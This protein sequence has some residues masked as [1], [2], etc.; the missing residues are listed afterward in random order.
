MGGRVVVDISVGGMWTVV[1]AVDERWRFGRTAGSFWLG[2][3]ITKSTGG[4][5]IRILDLG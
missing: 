2:E 5:F 4:Y 3:L 1:N